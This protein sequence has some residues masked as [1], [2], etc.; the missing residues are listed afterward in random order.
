TTA[1]RPKPEYMCKPSAAWKVALPAQE[2]LLYDN[3]YGGFSRTD[4]SYVITLAPGRQTPAP[5]CNPLCSERFGTLA[6]ESGLVFSYAG[7]SN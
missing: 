7:N 3:G 5:W 6:G 1:A 2:E 4:G